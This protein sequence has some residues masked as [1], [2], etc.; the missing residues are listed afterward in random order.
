MEEDFEILISGFLE[1]EVGISE[2][3]IS[4]KL[5][6]HL[7]ANLLSLHDRKLMPM[8]GIGNVRAH[9]LDK[10]IRNDRIYWFDRNN[11]DPYENEFLDQIDLFIKYLNLTCYTGIKAYEFHYALYEPGSFYVKH[12]DQFN[13]DQGRMFSLITYL[14]DTWVEK[15]G[16]ELLIYQSTAE[17]KI[18]PTLCKTIFFKSNQLAHE[19]LETKKAR[20]SITG[21][22]KRE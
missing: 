12:K 6:H 14:N 18:A 10:T 11:H 3:F 17:Q 5:A 16:G 13:N 2:H 4:E 21:W 20:L 1:S 7:R 22:L 8:A 9:A 15:D 19:V